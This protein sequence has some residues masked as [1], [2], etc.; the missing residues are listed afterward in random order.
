MT[1]SEVIKQIK[2]KRTMATKIDFSYFYLSMLC[3]VAFMM[4]LACS[5]E[6]GFLS[7]NFLSYGFFWIFSNV[8]SMLYINERNKFAKR[9]KSK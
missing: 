7:P 1:Q 9:G 4:G 8:L 2:E 6:W 5:L 3:G